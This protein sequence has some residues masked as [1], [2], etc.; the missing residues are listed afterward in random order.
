MTK[1][2]ILLLLLLILAFQVAF[3]QVLLIEG[4]IID[5]FTST[6]VPFA[7]IGITGKSI[8]S[9][10]DVEGNFKFSIPAATVSQEEQ[11][12][13]SCI[14]YKA[15]KATV[16]SFMHRPQ[17]IT[18]A[19]SLIAL[20]EVTI[21]PRKVK[22]KTFGRTGNST[23]MAAKMF[24]ENNLVSDELAKEQG[25]IINIDEEILLKDFNMHVAFNRFKYVK[26]RL[27]IYSVN[28]GLPQESLLRENVIFD[29]TEQ[30]GWI[31]V[32][33]SKYH[34]FL[35]GLDKVAVTVQWL[36]SEAI[37]GNRKSF[38]VSAVPVPAHSILFRNKS[39]D[40]WKEVKPG[41]LSFYLTADSYKG[42]NKNLAAA[43]SPT[44]NYVLP[45]SLK[46]LRFLSLEASKNLD[47]KHH[48]GDSV[49]AGH[50]INI[51]GTKL[52]YEIYGKG[53]P[54]MLLHGN[55]QSISAYYQQIN[56]LSQHF[57][58]IAVDTRGQ[59]KSK[60][61]TAKELSYDLFASDMK[62]LLDSL[63]LKQ[64]HILGWSDGGNTALKMAI[65]YPA[66]V[67]KI[68]I[69]GANLVPDHTAIESGLLDLFKK[70]L[71]ELKYK[72][73]ELSLH[74]KRLLRLL[75]TEPNMSYK[76]LKAIFVPVLIMSGEHDVILES[77]TKAIADNIKEAKLVIFKDASHYAPQEVPHEFNREVI[78]FFEQKNKK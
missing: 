76:E 34:I 10:A 39:Q 53:E 47:T 43:S 4:K 9:I 70:Q 68:A 21:K 56:T 59:G 57:K 72:D 69:M 24:T 66:Y 35:E 78:S 25:T 75:L 5:R 71:N 29:V 50:F 16:S 60:D 46:Y 1:A 18:L 32:D 23:M 30:R 15:Y 3:S 6:P 38:G 58:I 7:S 33:L 51:T 20:G 61:N 52:Y 77:H 28:N 19:P 40:Q 22:T 44:D 8:G 65:Q 2:K 64:V 73:D 67:N 45:D 49:Q 31:K 17:R 48:Y 41:Y 13:I 74:Q 63:N 11:I 12:I 37:Q 26:F 36:E 62:Q 54:L 55:G 14:G 42:E 27:N